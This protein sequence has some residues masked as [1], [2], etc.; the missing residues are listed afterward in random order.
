ML[1][2]LVENTP[3]ALMTSSAFGRR[4]P[5]W[6]F[7]ASPAACP[8]GRSLIGSEK[9]WRSLPR[10]STAQARY[11]GPTGPIFWINRVEVDRD[12]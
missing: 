8:H 5:D 11:S 7:N 10:V 9:A 2:V 3:R 12:S 6:L 4:T 1:V